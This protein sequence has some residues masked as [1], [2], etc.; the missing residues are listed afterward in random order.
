MD[1]LL[2][3]FRELKEDFAEES[4]EDSDL[5]NLDDYSDEDYEKLNKYALTKKCDDWEDA[6]NELTLQQTKEFIDRI[7]K[8]LFGNGYYN[9]K[10]TTYRL[11][12]DHIE[13]FVNG[14]FDGNYYMQYDRS[15]NADR[16]YT[17][18]GEEDEE[19]EEDDLEDLEDFDE[20]NPNED[21]DWEPLYYLTEDEVDWNAFYLINQ[22]DGEYAKFKTQEEAE[23]YGLK[24]QDDNPGYLTYDV[25]AFGDL[26]VL[27]GSGMVDYIAEKDEDAEEE[28]Y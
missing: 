14:K 25:D 1:I 22:V 27:P 8:C 3:S 16:L 18:T 19:D 12:P 15:V 10:E 11:R 21:V 26:F 17:W 28:E 13:V 2:E 23:A 20:D 7:F 24:M 6:L 5:N 4:N 9:E